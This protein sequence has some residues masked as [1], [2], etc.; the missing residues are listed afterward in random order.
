MTVGDRFKAPDK[1]EFSA[2]GA[3]ADPVIKNGLLA[4]FVN[5]PPE[6]PP[7]VAARESAGYGYKTVPENDYG[8]DN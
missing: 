8:N 7:G 3:A 6:N 2:P 4:K 1:A 5:T